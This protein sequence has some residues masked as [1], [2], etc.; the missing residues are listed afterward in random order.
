MGGL[1]RFLKGLA[2]TKI[3]EWVWQIALVLGAGLATFYAYVKQVGMLTPILLSMGAM[4]MVAMALVLYRAN[5]FYRKEQPPTAETVEGKIRDWIDRSGHGVQRIDDAMAHFNFTV[6]TPT[7]VKI[8]VSRSLKP[9]F[10]NYVQFSCRVLLAEKQAAFKSLS[11]LQQKRQI[12]HVKMELARSGVEWEMPDL[13]QSGVL[14]A[15]IV[16]ISVLTEY[17][18]NKAL[19]KVQ[20]GRM[21]VSEVLMAAL[22]ETETQL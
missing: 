5:A 8:S 1:L 2:E 19:L 20:A 13:V 16:P 9:H 22:E 15:E 10:T 6:T 11:P 17:G 12:R 18:F 7:N 3:G 14:I 21:L 4:L